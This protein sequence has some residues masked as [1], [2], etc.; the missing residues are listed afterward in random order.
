[1]TIFHHTFISFNLFHS[2]SALMFRNERKCLFIIRWTGLQSHRNQLETHNE[3]EPDTSTAHLNGWTERDGEE[4]SRFSH[5]PHTVCPLWEWGRTNKGRDEC[6]YV[7]FLAAGA[8]RG[9]EV[10][11]F[12][13]KTLLYFWHILHRS[14]LDSFPN[15]WL[16]ALSPDHAGS[17]PAI[18]PRLKNTLIISQGSSGHLESHLQKHPP[19]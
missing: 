1:M 4:E 2:A 6:V 17:A 12:Y 8:S 9:E 18:W 11:G 14:K 5:C 16:P 13:L 15:D 10:L 19:L 3:C 7:R